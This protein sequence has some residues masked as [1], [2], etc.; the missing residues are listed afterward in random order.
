MNLTFFVSRPGNK[1]YYLQNLTPWHFASRTKNPAEWQKI[2]GPLSIAEKRIIKKFSDILKN[3]GYDRDLKRKSTFLGIPFFTSNTEKE[4]LEK[5]KDLL[6][7]KQFEVFKE[8]FDIFEYKFSIIWNHYSNNKPALRSIKNEIK[9]TQFKKAINEATLICGLKKTPDI[10]ISVIFSPAPIGETAAGT[11]LPGHNLITMELPISFSDEWTLI[12]SIGILLHEIMHIMLN[13]RDINKK[14][15]ASIKKLKLPQRVFEKP[16][17][18]LINESIVESFAPAGFIIQNHYPN[19]IADVV[20]ANADRAY[21]Q[22]KDIR[23][24]LFWA[25]YPTAVFYGKNK[26]SIDQYFINR[27]ASSLKNII[28][29]KIRG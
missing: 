8:T 6:T 18:S 12:Y 9:K 23:N 7:Q 29:K 1:F 4:A 13:E 15:D 26:Q 25:N 10:K 3:E 14:I 2:T 28:A 17:L 16:T 21:L 22:K 24:A 27:A 19:K 11:A 20:L 5:V